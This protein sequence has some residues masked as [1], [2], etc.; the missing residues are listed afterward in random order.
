MK[1]EHHF[2]SVDGLSVSGSV[3]ALFVLPI[4]RNANGF[5]VREL[6][7]LLQSSRDE[8]WD[9]SHPDALYTRT[10]DDSVVIGF[11][12][13]NSHPEKKNRSVKLVNATTA[14]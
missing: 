9:R 4:S 11:R 6:R 14:K 5:H 8:L 10:R 2:L 13:Y 1:K 3:E 7:P 12:G